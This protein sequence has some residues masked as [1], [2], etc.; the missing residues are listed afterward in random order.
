[1]EIFHNG[2]TTAAP[3]SGATEEQ[4]TFVVHG[5]VQVWNKFEEAIARDLSARRGLRQPAR[6]SRFG[7]DNDLLFRV[8]TT[9]NAAPSL[10]MGELSSALFVPLS[11]ATRVVNTLVERGYVQRFPHPADRRV[12]HVRFTPR[13]RRLY[14]FVDGRIAERVRLISA[15]LTTDEMATL[16]KLLSKVAVAVKETL[17]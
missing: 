17:K 14:K 4:V 16:I 2:S 8:G 5:F 12:V 15:Y 1:M 11:T 9:L 7:A 10:T 13:G 6:E 3:A